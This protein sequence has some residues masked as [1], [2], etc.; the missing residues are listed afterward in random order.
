MPA[1]RKVRF[2]SRGIALAAHLYL[3]PLLA[4]DRRKAAV[5]VSHP[6]TGVKEETAGLHA[7]LLAQAGFIALAF[8]AA[9]QGESDGR[10]RGLEDPHQRVEDVRAAVSF[11]TTVSMVDPDRVGALGLCASGGYVCSAA[12]TDLR[13][14]AVAAVSAVDAGRLARD[15]LRDRAV[16][17]P[18]LDPLDRPDRLAAALAH[19]ARLR[20]LEARGHPLTQRTAAL[21]ADAPDFYRGAGADAPGTC[22]RAAST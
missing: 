17:G 22:C 15:G 6:M 4:A 2:P 12:Q 3:P 9:Y 21:A 10:P 7:R 8:D 14:K 20:T 5:V 16:D 11:L 18:P 19:A 13:I 1:I